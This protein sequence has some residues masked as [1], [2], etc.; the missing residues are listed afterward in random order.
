MRRRTPLLR[1]VLTATALLSAA[2]AALLLVPLDR[3]VA[4][5]GFLAGGSTAVRAPLDARIERV[6]VEP[7]DAVQPGDPLI[8]LEVAELANERARCEARA[9]ALEER[10]Q[11]LRAQLGH[12]R[13]TLQVHERNLALLELERAG[14]FEEAAQRRLR[15][16]DRL[17]GEN[18]V[19]EL[20]YE[21]AL[22]ERELAG[23]AHERARL[24]LEALP[25]AQAAATDELE[26]QLAESRSRLDELHLE[27]AELARREALSTLVAPLAGV[28]SSVVP[29]ELVG[30]R[31]LAGEELLRLGHGP[32]E[33]FEGRVGDLARAQVRAGLPVRLRVDG[34]PWLLHGSVRGRTGF[35][36]ERSQGPG[37]PVEVALAGERQGLVLREGMAATARILVEESVPLWRLCLE[38]VTGP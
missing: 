38:R 33:R 37:F 30:R 25:A 15:A 17:R 28:V 5:T 18:L 8:V 22:A 35:V 24:A 6:L 34:Y 9:R 29:S 11:A 16:Q 7:G 20:A 32:A 4:A 13:E 1:S 14:V 36:D 3:V 19:S 26:A 23:I 12:L 2:G 31:V 10:V 27:A 21:D